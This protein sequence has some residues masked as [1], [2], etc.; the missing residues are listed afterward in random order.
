VFSPCGSLTKI[1]AFPA[2]GFAAPGRD[3][4]PG[5]CCLYVHI[6]PLQKPAAETFSC[7]VSQAT[8]KKTKATYYRW[9][10]NFVFSF[11]G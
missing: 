10:R 6:Y 5:L 2:R 11:Y 9:P 1:R 4:A 8:E 3:D 7:S